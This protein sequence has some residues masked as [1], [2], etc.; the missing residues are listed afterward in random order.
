MRSILLLTILLSYSYN[1]LSQCVDGDC[2]D[3][4]G[5]I[6]SNNINTKYVG[7]FKNG[8]FHGNGKLY[9]IVYKELQPNLYSKKEDTVYLAPELNWLPIRIDHL[10]KKGRK[11][12]A[13]I[14]KK[15]PN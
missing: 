3:G 7:E 8:E 4:Y 6:V 5:I 10:D 11:M 2:I 1:S 14:E 15:S 13:I 12:I 9:N